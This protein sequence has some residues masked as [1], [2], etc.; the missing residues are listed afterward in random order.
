MT[1]WIE[2]NI[3]NYIKQKNEKIVKQWG[4][5]QL[6][7]ILFNYMLLEYRIEYVDEPINAF[8]NKIEFE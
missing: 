4:A 1:L 2:W 5:L 3:L 6:Q 7:I 8:I